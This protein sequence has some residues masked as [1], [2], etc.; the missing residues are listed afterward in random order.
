MKH[1]YQHVR[2]FLIGGLG[3][4]SLVACQTP[5]STPDAFSFASKTGVSITETG[6]IES[7]SVTITGMTSAAS[8]NVTGGKYG[9]DGGTCVAT[10]GTISAGQKMRL[11][12]TAPNKFGQDSNVNIDVGGVK[13]SFTASAETLDAI[14][15]AP[16]SFAANGSADSAAVTVVWTSSLTEL[17][18]VATTSGVPGAT[19]GFKIGSSTTC[20]TSGNAKIND[21]IKACATVPTSTA[22]GS[23]VTVSLEFGSSTTGKVSKTFEVTVGALAVDSVA[24]NPSNFTSPAATV[25]KST[26][27][28][29]DELTVY[30]LLTGSSVPVSAVGGQV[31]V[32]GAA[33]TTVKNGDKIKVSLTSSATDDTLSSAI[34]T[35]GTAGKEV[36]ATFYVRTVG[37][38]GA[39]EYLPNEVLTDFR[40]LP[41]WAKNDPVPDGFNVADTSPS[42]VYGSGGPWSK[43]SDLT[44]AEFIYVRSNGDKLGFIKSTVPKMDWNSCPAN[45]NEAAIIAAGAASPNKFG[46]TTLT[47][48]VAASGTATTVSKVELKLKV[49]HQSRAD[50][51]I[52]LVSPN[53]TRVVIFDLEKDSLDKGLRGTQFSNPN[54]YAPEGYPLPESNGISLI[55][56]DAAVAPPKDT[57][58]NWT[59]VGDE[60]A[61]IPYRCGPNN[62]TPTGAAQQKN[63]WLGTCYDNANSD[64]KGNYP[65]GGTG[66]GSFGRVRPSNPLSAFNGLPIAG[67]WTLEIEDRAPGNLE[68]NDD[69]F[70]PFRPLDLPGQNPKD[71]YSTPKRSVF[72]VTGDDKQLVRQAAL[73][74]LTPK[75]RVAVLTVK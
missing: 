18:V 70:P 48:N 24:L 23:K 58:T 31:L 22:N 21:S 52:T 40:P 73:G 56:D 41:R 33:A 67:T 72:A 15:F 30:G 49:P 59:P 1:F 39:D 8:I 9:I 34:V 36:K 68:S 55:F 6:G 5:D 65:G 63:N 35:V 27:S 10:S 20:Q 71:D 46:K 37:I 66:F 57:N 44:I 25:A 11:C 53:G 54:V 13:S 14:T 60:A 3:L 26:V 47:F 32:N 29:S 61:T 42:C 43:V 50:L 28:T 51:F 7:E 17:D 2:L 38:L 4:A 75:V 69:T 19:G 45:W 62:R 64:R 16:T 74:K 12:A